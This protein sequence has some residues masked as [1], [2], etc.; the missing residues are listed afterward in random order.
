LKTDLKEDYL[1]GVQDRFE[2]RLFTRRGDLTNAI[3][4]AIATNAL[5]AMINGVWGTITHLADEYRVSRP[6]VYSLADKL[7]E[8][9]RFLFGETAEFIPAS[10]ARE[11]S[12]QMMLSRRL[13][14]RSSIG[15]I[16]TIMNRFA[17]DLHSA[18]SISQTLSR[19]GS[20]L[21]TTL[22]T[23]KG[24]IQYLVLASDELFSKTTPILVTV[25]PCSS[26]IVRIE[27]ADIRQ[28]EDWKRHF[29][30]LYDNGMQAIYLVC[31]EGQGIRAG[32]AVI[33]VTHRAHEPDR[34]EIAS[35]QAVDLWTTPITTTENTHSFR[36]ESKIQNLTHL[37]RCCLFKDS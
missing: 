31:D 30:C 1:L 36:R 28:A 6:F 19:I 34:L 29:E 9:G 25:D 12:I 17:Y 2:R 11:H 15:A 5:H 23:E 27:L 18:G 3:R 4:L 26:A 8:A 16:A 22:S 7:K 24:L 33:G 21:P 32:H 10:S 37:L 20:L 13:E 14:G 35:H